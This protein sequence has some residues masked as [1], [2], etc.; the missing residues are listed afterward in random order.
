MLRDKDIR[1][2]LFDFLEEWLGKIRIIEEKQM[3]KSRAD[4]VMVQPDSLA[5]IEIKSDA[6]SYAR[7]QRQVKDYDSYFDLNYAV[8]GTSHALHIEEHVPDWWGIITVDEVDGCADFYVLRMPKQNPKVDWKKKLGLLWRPELVHIQERNGLPKYRDKNK[9]FV[10]GKILEKV[11]KE[12][13]ARQISDELF[14]R[15][16]NEIAEMIQEYRKERAGKN[17]VRKT[18]RRRREPDREWNNRTDG[19]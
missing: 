17:H 18:R 14:E 16:Y 6:D 1:E 12:L 8:V 19:V 4:L 7:L 2:P 9:Q 15:D 11:P 13:L 3:G 5:G 10:I